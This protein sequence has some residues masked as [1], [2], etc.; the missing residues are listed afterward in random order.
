[1][2]FLKRTEQRERSPDDVLGTA[3][4]GIES[5]SGSAVRR[6]RL[7]GNQFHWKQVLNFLSRKEGTLGSWAALPLQSFVFEGNTW[8]CAVEVT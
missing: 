8:N 5:G 4:A 6:H 3:A 1:M 7:P 2:P